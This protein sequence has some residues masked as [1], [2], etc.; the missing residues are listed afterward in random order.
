MDKSYKGSV[1]YPKQL[2]KTGD[3]TPEELSFCSAL[4]DTLKGDID[5][6]DLAF[7]Q[8]FAD[9]RTVV[10]GDWDNDFLRYHFGSDGFWVSVRMYP[11]IVADYEFNPLFHAQANKRQLHWRASIG[12]D[13]IG[14]LHDVMIRSCKAFFGGPDTKKPKSS[15]DGKAKSHLQLQVEDLVSRTPGLDDFLGDGYELLS[16]R[17]TV[18]AGTN[19]HPAS[20]ALHNGSALTCEH[21]KDNP[22]DSEAIAVFDSSHELVGYLPKDGA[23]K[24]MVLRAISDGLTIKAIV[25]NDGTD[26]GTRIKRKKIH[27]ALLN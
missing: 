4:A 6:E 10:Y 15:A 14:E 27:I 23:I 7:E 17:D 20:E 19:F 24:R 21:D 1:I 5:L 26:G 9:Y 13:E 2:V 12:S 8:R 22:Y 16:A 3:M 25:V 11:G 18:L